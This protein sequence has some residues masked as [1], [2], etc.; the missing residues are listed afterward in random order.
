MYVGSDDHKF[1]AIDQLTGKLAWSFKTGGPVRDTGTLDSVGLL[2]IGSDD[3]HLYVLHA[4]SG[5]EDFNF[6]IG[7]AI[8]SWMTPALA[9]G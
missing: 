7:S 9:P 5:K 4:S 8:V 2:Y 3:G 6:S 1:Y